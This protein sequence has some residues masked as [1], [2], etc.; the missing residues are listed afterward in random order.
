MSNYDASQTYVIGNVVIGSDSARYQLTTKSP[1]TRIQP[2]SHNASTT[3]GLNIVPDDN[4]DWAWARF[5]NANDTYQT[6]SF[7]QAMDSYGKW[8]IFQ[9]LNTST[10]STPS[11]LTDWSFKS[12]IVNLPDYDATTKYSYGSVVKY[13]PFGTMAYYYGIFSDGATCQPDPTIA[14]G[15]WTMIV[16]PTTT[17]TT[18]TA[19]PSTT[20]TTTAP[21]STTTTTTTAPPS[22]LYDATNLYQVGDIVSGSDGNRYQLIVQAPATQ[23]GP[24]NSAIWLFFGNTFTWGNRYEA[25][26][27]VWGYINDKASPSTPYGVYRATR[28]ITY[29]TGYPYNNP[30]SWNFLGLQ[31]QILAYN[32]STLYVYNSL[33]K[34]NNANF[35]NISTSPKVQPDPTNSSSYWNLIIPPSTTTT[36]TTIPFNNSYSATKIYDIGDQVSGSD[37]GVYELSSHRPATQITPSTSIDNPWC[38][39]PLHDTANDYVVG[40]Y[41]LSN[42]SSSHLS[43]Y[44]ALQ[45][46]SRTNLINVNSNS[47][48]PS[49]GTTFWKFISY[50]DSYSSG[51]ITRTGLPAYSATDLY[52]I[53]S[54]V[55]VG[56]LKDVYV[57]CSM[58]STT[59]KDPTDLSS[60]NWT[61]IT[62]P[63]TT[64]DTST[65]TTTTTAPPGN[66]T[67]TTTTTAPPGSSTTTTTTTAPPSTTTTTTT[68]P[69]PPP[70][71][72]YVNFWKALAGQY[73]YIV[74]PLPD[75]LLHPRTIN[76]LTISM[77]DI[78]GT[79]SKILPSSYLH[80]VFWSK[81]EN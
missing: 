68:A 29:A 78:D 4:A 64:T 39:V 44:Q 7:V 6:G 19:P 79:D 80:L 73:N 23:S 60:T 46:I 45:E 75:S 36:T 16:P 13:I 37:G 54:L 40:D 11:S 34:A 49:V 66:S 17:T 70:V 35:I 38:L 12:L 69:P 59:E 21:P 47:L 57:L 30:S 65:T 5:W 24:P 48:N 50:R 28:L 22:N 77:S 43:V 74:S 15:F 81:R 67:T 14:S 9:A 3:G 27:V 52:S 20:T 32:A 72:K 33:V 31:S 62:Y 26:D 10:N 55:Y 56:A 61:T 2:S 63:P 42:D 71:L 41:V 18:T 58:P 51:A 25:G 53:G 76:E 8:C 1:S